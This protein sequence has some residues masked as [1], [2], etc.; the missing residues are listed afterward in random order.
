MSR[1]DDRLDPGTYQDDEPIGVGP[2]HDPESY[3]GWVWIPQRLFDRV[4]L[5][6]AAYGL[7]VLPGVDMNDRNV[8]R[9]EQ[10][11]TLLDEIEFIGTLTQDAALLEQLVRLRQIAQVVTRRARPAELIIEGP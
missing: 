10:V 1:Y 7:H 3:E 2:A 9:P 11:Q 6:A 8:L 4:R 5:I